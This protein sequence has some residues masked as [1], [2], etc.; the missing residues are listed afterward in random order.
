M[1]F[2]LYLI[3]NVANGKRYVGQTKDSVASRWSKHLYCARTGVGGC[4]KLRKAMRK[5]GV[6]AFN[7]RP[8]LFVH[9]EAE[10]DICEEILIDWLRLRD[11]RFGYNITPGGS[12]ATA[13]AASAIGL[14]AIA[15][16]PLASERRSNQARLLHTFRDAAA[17]SKR[18]AERNR[19]NAKLT[20]E[21]VR[22]IRSSHSSYTALSMKYGVAVST[23]CDIRKRRTWAH[24]C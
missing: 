3:T 17:H 4:V 6:G 19:A 1:T 11:D 24:I 23:L 8:V 15:D 5:Y 9:T 18:T 21:D 16:D 2:T 14:A 7:I 20:D 12:A 13:R 10:A 22:D